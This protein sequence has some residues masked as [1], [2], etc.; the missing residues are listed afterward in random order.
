MEDNSEILKTKVKNLSKNKGKLSKGETVIR[1]EERFVKETMLTTDHD[2]FEDGQ[3]FAAEARRSAERAHAPIGNA[4][5]LAVKDP[6]RTTENLGEMIYVYTL[7][8]LKRMG[9]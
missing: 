4:L 8:I 1:S 7:W 5:R 2:G 9:K 3:D 6:S